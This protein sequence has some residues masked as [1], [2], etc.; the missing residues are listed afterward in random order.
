MFIFL[1]LFFRFLSNQ[2]ESEL[3]KEKKKQQINKQNLNFSA[4][5]INPRKKN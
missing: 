5:D 4:V 3:L 2:T 1:S